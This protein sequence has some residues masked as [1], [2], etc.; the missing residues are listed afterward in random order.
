MSI[1]MG[2]SI[3][4]VIPAFNEEKRISAAIR[5]IHVY[6]MEQGADFEIL[7]VDDGS[8]DRTASVVSEL[9]RQFPVLKLV[10][11]ER[12]FGKGRAVTEGMLRAQGDFVL[13]TDADQSTTIDH[14]P[15]LVAPMKELG[16][17][18][19][20]ASRGV[21][22]ATLL[23]RQ[24]RHR[25]ALGKL[26]GFVMR[27]FL[28]RGVKDTQC[29]FKCFT[30]EAAHTIFSKVTCQNAL[31]DMEVLLLAG[32]YQYWIAEVP[33]TW[34]H[35]PD[36]RLVYNLRGS[37]GLLRELLRIRCHWGIGL[38]VKFRVPAAGASKE[39][40]SYQVQDYLVREFD[41]YATTKYNIILQWLFRHSCSRVLNVGCGSGELNIVLS[42]HGYVV[43]SIDPSAAAVALAEQRRAQG[44]A[45]NISIHQADLFGYYPS[46]PYDAILCLDVLEHIEDDIAA[47]R[48]LSEILAPGGILL[49]SA[50]A[51]PSLYGYHDQQLGHYRR[52]S[53]TQL[54]RTL[55]GCFT[56]DQSRYFGLSLI[57][58]AFLYSRLLR[59]PYPVRQSDNS[60]SR[61]ILKMESM[62]RPPLGTSLL[63]QATKTR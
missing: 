26:F 41:Q 43:D 19:A 4:V 30:R 21:K 60:L 55:D 49:I 5:S 63:V 14:L 57:P 7:V 29:G 42:N 56:I 17:Q 48:R 35:N 23:R 62:V 28:V 24:A 31:F 59:K 52:Y 38:P 39:Q 33:V 16:C 61:F 40:S 3:S 50:P 54:M 6:L 20:I 32:R 10:Q 34:V 46:I 37:L 13:F 45:L 51:L 18:V 11:L 1:L 36:S 44:G 47:V 25:E 9:R 12:N 2:L 58:L 15:R 22:G 8:R 53:K 27:L